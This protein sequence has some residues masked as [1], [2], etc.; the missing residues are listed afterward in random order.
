MVHRASVLCRHF[1]RKS[2]ASEDNFVFRMGNIHWKL[3]QACVFSNLI[4]R[5]FQFDLTLYYA[6]LTLMCWFLTICVSARKDALFFR[7]SK[8]VLVKIPICR[9]MNK[10][11]IDVFLCILEWITDSL[12]SL[13]LLYFVNG[14]FTTN[15]WMKLC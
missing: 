9:L 13:K 10:S 15:L 6:K 2:W 12:L 14:Q 1:N 3:R 4:L 11:Q 8:S 7:S 5:N